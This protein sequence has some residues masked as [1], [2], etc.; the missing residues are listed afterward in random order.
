MEKLSAQQR[1]RPISCRRRG[2]GQQEL[3]CSLCGVWNRHSIVNE[4]GSALF[5]VQKQPE[6]P[7]VN[8]HHK[9]YGFNFFLN[10]FFSTSLL[11]YIVIFRVFDWSIGVSLYFSSSGQCKGLVHD[12]QVSPHKSM[13]ILKAGWCCLVGGHC[14]NINTPHQWDAERTPRDQLTHTL[15][16]HSARPGTITCEWNCHHCCCFYFIENYYTMGLFVR[17]SCGVIFYILAPSLMAIGVDL[18]H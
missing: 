1:L 11:L 5:S 2:D 10:I 9:V 4:A 15:V 8:S 16:T 12:I 14:K 6:P 3:S 7:Y 18:C 13:G 17:V